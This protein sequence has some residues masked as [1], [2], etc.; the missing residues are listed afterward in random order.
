MDEIFLSASVPVPGR[1]HY[2]ETANPFLIQCAV[3]ELVITVIRS[4]R[5]VWGGH[6]SIT[7]MVASIC[8]DLG[9]DYSNAVVL[10]QSRFFDGKAPE[11]NK[12]FGTVEYVDAVKGDLQAS[13]QSMRDA[14][15]SR[16]ALV[17]AVFIGGM[18]GVE[19]EHRLFTNYHPK[20]RV[21]PVPAT[22]GAALDLAKRLGVNDEATLQD[23]DFARMFHVMLGQLQIAT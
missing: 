19:T 20:S 9:V 8:T 22:G 18:D 11:E 17:A 3:R 13:L 4:H 2:V 12:Q 6:P 7:P 14:M 1:G 23:V 16:P 21:L 5:I 15:L 10:Y